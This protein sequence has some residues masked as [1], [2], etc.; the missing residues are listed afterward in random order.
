MSTTGVTAVIPARYAS[1]RFPAKMLADATGW[2][3]IRHT[4]E[5]ASR[6]ALVDRVI[7]AAD[8]ER[9]A[10]AVRGFGGEVIMTRVDHPNGTS[11]IAEVAEQ[12]ETS[13]IVNVQGDEPDID[14]AVIDEAVRT[15][16]HADDCPIGT[17]AS[18]FADDEDPAN[19]NIVKVVISRSG[20]AMYFSRAF[21]PHARDGGPV[22]VLKHIGL[23]VYRRAFLAQYVA[24]PATPLEQAERLEQLRVLEHDIPMVVGRA[25]ARHHGIDTPEQYDAFVAR[26]SAANPA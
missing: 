12:L 10:D 14:P 6:A 1:E 4:Y 11:R 17:I 2:P 22:S 16:R 9:I 19:P 7:V 8:D 23:Y 25:H 13:I 5:Q 24:L 21:I 15:L 18:P 20:R 26:W 3:L